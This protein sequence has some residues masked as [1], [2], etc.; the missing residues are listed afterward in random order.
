MSSPSLSFAVV[1]ISWLSHFRDSKTLPPIIIVC[2]L[3]RNLPNNV[4]EHQAGFIPDLKEYILC[5]CLIPGK[6]GI[7]GYDAINLAWTESFGC[8][9]RYV[10]SDLTKNEA[11]LNLASA[12]WSAFM[13]V[14]NFLVSNVALTVEVCGEIGVETIRPALLICLWDASYLAF[15]TLWYWT[16]SAFFAALS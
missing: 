16:K 5:D 14:S 12:G 9:I 15:F 2:T 6:T 3:I 4:A 10:S 11:D 7:T 1:T 13:C 8:D